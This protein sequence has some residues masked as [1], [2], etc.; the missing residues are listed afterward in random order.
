MAIHGRAD[1]ST[2]RRPSLVSWFCLAQPTDVCT[3]CEPKTGALVWRFQAAPSS[4]QIIAFGRLESPWRVHGNVLV[5][6]GLVYFTAGRSSFLDGGLRLYALEPATGRLVHEARLDTWSPHRDDA[7]GKPFVPGY[8]IEGARSD[9]LVSQGDSIYLGQVK[10]NSPPGT[11]GSPLRV[12]PIRSG[13]RSRW[14]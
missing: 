11:A 2:R 7:V 10:F 6:E 8:H 14:T 1:Q 13:N 12:A 4:R 3:V 5:H 9:I